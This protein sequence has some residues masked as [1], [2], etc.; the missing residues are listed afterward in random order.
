MKNSILDAIG[1]TPLVEIRR[2]S[3]KAGVRIF[4]KLEYMNPGGS[5]KDRAALFMINAGEA[6]GRLTRQKTVIEATSG[7]T[8]IGLAMICAVKGYDL[9]LTMAENASEERKRILKA[10]GAKL[11]L[12]P[13]HLGS[14]GAIEEAYRLARENPDKY[15]ITDQYNNEANWQA[16]YHTTGPEILAQAPEKPAS[17]V[18]T[19]GTSGTLMGLSR[20][21]REHC[22][23]TRIV[24]AE[25]F[26]GHRIQGLKN[27]K[28]SYTPEIY[29]KT[30]LDRI[31]HIDDDLAFETARQ[32]A[33]REGLFVGMSSGAA[34][35]AA[36]EEAKTLDTGVVVVIFP[37][38]G[39]RYLSTSL[40]SVDHKLHLALFDTLTGRKQPFSPIKTDRVSLYTCGPTVYQRMNP[41]KFRR[42]VFTDLLVR[43]LA[44]H[45]IEVNHV[46][47]ITDYDDRTIDGAGRA[48]VDLDAFVRPHIQTFLADLRRLGIRPAQ[49]YPRVSDHVGDMA[50]LTRHLLNRGHAYEKL[51]SVYFDITSV[52]EYGR[53]SRM[54]IDK[55]RLGATVDLDEYEKQNPRDFTLFKRV[56]LSELRRGI[57]M[58]TE[59]GHVRPS[60]HLQCA[61]LSMLYLGTPFDIHTGSREL[62]FP[63]HENERAIARAARERPLANVWLHCDPVRYDGSLGA[64]SLDEI[65]LDTLAEQG[66]EDR[67]IRF[68]LM[69]G[70][71]RKG[72]ELSARS[73]GDA[74]ATL[75]KINRCIAVLS[76][77][78]SRAGEVPPVPDRAGGDP[79]RVLPGAGDG[80]AAGPASGEI[81]QLLYDIRQGVLTA[82]GDDLKISAAL[83]ALM[84]GVKA[85]N[86]L[87]SRS[88]ITPEEAGRILA[89]FREVDSIF[90]VC[91]FDE[92][93]EYSSRAADLI[94]QRAAAREKKDWAAAD[95]IRQELAAMGVQVHD[96]KV[97]TQ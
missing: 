69:S 43:Y 16:H 64:A 63:H 40:F 76:Q 26:L 25:P 15:F 35:A 37:D 80:A 19:V 71:Y 2:M 77:I 96:Q 9:A 48:G 57:G 53:L 12:T 95:R 45:G 44:F 33:S 62:V 72:L 78:R 14:D 50:E 58:K 86:A 21:F 88:R 84:A 10:R 90:Q 56:R 59:W 92:K 54:D 85:V 97:R 1:N 27:M 23:K 11:I 20:Y 61:A 8:G 82:L 79:D 60:L 24:C 17:V 39:E 32:L 83:A 29:D 89:G 75:A 13:R 36:M 52:P 74:R 42:Y 94:R 46:V 6:S 65:T 22:P 5:V 70:H 31:L 49:A 47:N 66:W 87:M 51:H 18:A 73:L 3:P 30:R 28:E 4:A 68:W 91:D 93:T 7:N 34:M 41:G 55:V 38:S 67:T 81:D